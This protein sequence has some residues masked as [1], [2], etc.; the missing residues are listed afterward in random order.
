[1]GI[2]YDGIEEQ[3]QLAIKRLRVTETALDFFKMIDDFDG[4]ERFFFELVEEWWGLLTPNQKNVVFMH[5]V[6]KFSFSSI[7]ELQ[8]VSPQAVSETFHWATKKSIRLFKKRR[9]NSK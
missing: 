7:A 2:D 3:T 1:M 4:E 6:Q 9:K 5:T 8:G